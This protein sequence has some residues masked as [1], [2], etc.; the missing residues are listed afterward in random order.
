MTSLY[1]QMMTGLYS[2]WRKRWYGLAAMWAVCLV[3]WIIVALIPNQYKSSARLYVDW[4]SLLPAELGFE[5]NNVLRQVD[6]VKR[7]LTSRVNLEKV[8]RRTELD[9]ALTDEKQV[10]QLIA[11]MTKAI[12]VQSQ[13]NDLFT[14]SYTASDPKRT[15]AENANLARRVVDNLIQIFMEE[16]VSSDRDN[17]NEAVRFFEDQLAQRERELEAA[18]ARKAEFEQ[19]YL[20]RLPGEGAIGSRVQ[21]ARTELDRVQLELVQAQNSLRALQAQVAGTPATIDAPA[22]VFDTGGPSYAAGSARSRIATIEAQISDGLARGWTDKHPDIVAMRQQITRLEAEAARESTPGSRQ[23]R[24]AQANPVYVNLRSMMFEKQS[25]VA[26]L[27]AR[28]AQLRADIDDLAKRQVEE[29]GIVAEQAKLNRDYD[30]LKR[31]YDELL[32]SRETIR[33]RSDVETKTQQVKFRVVDPPSQP[34]VPVAPNRPLMLSL[35]LLAGLGAG[36][37]TAFVASQVH[38]TFPTS[39]RLQGN[40]DL[41]VLGSVSEIVSTQQY[42]QNRMWLVGFGVLALGLLAIYAAL[43]VSELIQ[44]A[45][46]A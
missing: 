20:G 23:Q 31:Q 7:T 43:L 24:A 5:Q 30:V 32:K 46:L 34:R 4:A 15:D 45:S 29:P 38:T 35:V 17:I 12:E 8:I 18:E 11:D 16:N 40:F 13:D 39:A 14:L 44:R 27:S 9:V 25:A 6:I 3:G 37:F 10:D 41:P 42:A 28:A 21:A 26:A 2:V 22:I 36:A 19:K 33:L 1:E